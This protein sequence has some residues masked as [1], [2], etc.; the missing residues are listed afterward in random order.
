MTCLCYIGGRPVYRGRIV[1][2]PRYWDD[3][4]VPISSTQFAGSN[5]PTVVTFIDNGAGST[6]VIG[7]SF[8]ATIEEERFF[9][10]QLSH[11]YAQ[12]TPIY[13]HVH[14]SPTTAGAGNVVWGLE[15]TIATA[16]QQ[17][18]TTTLTTLTAAASGTARMHQVNAFSAVAMVG[19]LIS[20]MISGRIY[21]DATNP[22]DT[23]AAGA[24]LHE[25]D[26]HYLKDTPGSKQEYVK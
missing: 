26:W 13:P 21:R 15:Y 24:I 1:Y 6:G 12:E 10:S 16:N 18:P 11:Q 23:Y 3:E 9:E 19:K 25:I 5:P 14:W 8:S 4:R 20:T 17:F 2:S 7:Y 22:A